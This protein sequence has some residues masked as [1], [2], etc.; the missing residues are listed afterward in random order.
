MRTVDHNIAPAILQEL[1][2]VHPWLRNFSGQVNQYISPEYYDRLLKPYVFGGHEDVGMF[3]DFL[4]GRTVVPN[5]DYLEL[6]CGTGRGGNIFVQ[7]VPAWRS[8]TMTDLSEHMIR[9]ARNKWAGQPKI[10]FLQGDHLRV[11]SAATDKY[12]G[13]YSLWSLSHS[14]HQYMVELGLE[15]ATELIRDTMVRF[16][17]D[18]LTPGAFFYLIHFDSCS[19]EQR[20]LMKHW[21][22]DFPIFQLGEQSPSKRLLDEICKDLEGSLITDLHVDHHIGEPIIYQTEEELLET[23]MNFHMETEYNR[24]VRLPE[25]LAALRTDARQF[26]LAAGRYAIRPGCFIYN[27]TRTGQGHIKVG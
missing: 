2:Q 12:H 24:S 6:G 26:S 8:L 10:R 23:M 22:Q 14:F 5:G 20:L 25:I 3:R 13:L 15:R 19:D 7:T 4:L 27:F 21:S 18:H 1:E 17:R 16:I 9:H 11:L